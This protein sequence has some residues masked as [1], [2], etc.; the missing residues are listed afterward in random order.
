M[1]KFRFASCI[2]L[3]VN[4]NLAF[5]SEEAGMPQLNPEF[6]T[7]QIFW[8]II[9]FS[10]LYLIIWKIFLPK[11]TYSIENRKSKIV[12]DLHE[13]QKLKETA[14][15]KL[16]EY[17]KIIE[18]SKRQAKK[19]IE[20]SKKKLDNDI[21]NKKKKF[22][23]EIEKELLSIEKEIQ[24]LKKSSLSSVSKI[25]ADAST[26]IIKQIINAEVNKSSVNAIVNDVIQRK[27]D[28]HI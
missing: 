15:S 25:A 9:I 4:M 8:L 22:S 18:D 11:I 17:S 23:E 24:E 26:E 2:A 6:W 20:D 19:I 7:A 28:K 12:G 3:S 10:S 13:A 16:K 21:E 27:V 5:G 1:K 14:E